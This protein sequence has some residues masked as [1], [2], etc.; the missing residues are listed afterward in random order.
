[1]NPLEILK[2]TPKTNCGECNFPTCLAFAAAVS[3]T[4]IPLSQC[5]HLDSESIDLN[6]QPN[7]DDLANL[8]R[9]RDLQLIATLKQKIEPLSFAQVA[10][11]IGATCAKDKPETLR[12]RYLGQNVTLSK[13]VLLIDDEI[14]EDPRDQILLYNYVSTGGGEQPRGDWIGMESLPNSLSKT[15][16]LKIYCEDRI[17]DFFSRFDASHLG[18]I[19]AGFDGIIPDN[20]QTSASIA[21]IIPVLP[22]VPQLLLY[23][24]AEP[25]DGFDAAAKILFDAGVLDFLDIESLVFSAERLTDHL[26]TLIDA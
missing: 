17:A 19:A 24:E 26:F 8:A 9:Q 20:Q 4:G 23:W 15:R 3:K 14:P 7:V 6:D 11:K 22:L 13:D 25:E 10:S 16:T 18:E 12:F 1:M 21:V 2:I 5:P